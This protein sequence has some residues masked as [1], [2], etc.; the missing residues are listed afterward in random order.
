MGSGSIVDAFACGQGDH[1]WAPTFYDSD[2]DG[3]TISEVD[4]PA[5][6][7]D[8]AFQEWACIHCGVEPAPATEAM[9]DDEW[10][11]ARLA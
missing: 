2:T 4:A 9:L 8:C 7:A 6:L 5:D 11:A 1:D 10:E 3:E